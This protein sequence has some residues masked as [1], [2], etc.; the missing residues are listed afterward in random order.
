LKTKTLTTI[1]LTIYILTLTFSPA[2]AQVAPGWQ[3]G[4]GWNLSSTVVITATAGS[5]GSITPQGAVNVIIGSDQTFTISP[6]IGY[7]IS[8]LIVDGSPVTIASNYTFTNVLTT[9]TITVYFTINTFT[10]TASADENGEIDPSGE[11]IVN[12]GNNQYFSYNANDGY[13]I[14]QLLIDGV[15]TSFSSM[16]GTYAFINVQANHTIAVS[17]TISPEPTPTPTPTP[18]PSTT[19]SPN[20]YNYPTETLDLY[21]RSDTYNFSD[22]SAYGLDTDYTN[23]YVSISATTT[24]EN[25]TITYGFRVFLVT[26]TTTFQ[27]LTDGTPQAQFTLS[28]NFTGQLSSSWNCPHTI[29]TLG[30]QAIK[31]NV[32]AQIDNGTWT[33]QAT[34]ITNTLITKEL[35]P[36]TW[37]F[38]LN[39]DMQQLVGNT[40][41]I[42]TFGDSDHRSTVTGVTIVTPKYP[43]IQLWQWMNCD[44]IGLI[45]GS[46]LYIIGP[47]IYLLVYA[48]IFGSLYLRHRTASPVVFIAIIFGGGF[49]LGAWVLLPLWAALPL[50]IF[51]ILAIMAIIFKVIR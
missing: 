42:L 23:D 9:H 16:S 49:G 38:S 35:M 28:S 39:L 46:Y 48:L 1:L 3:I 45:I 41:S 12:Y 20:P 50:S 31:I 17:T 2:L 30:T 25:A 15:S 19:S 8:S 18:T 11:I 13:I 22:I 14:E 21:M 34:Y 37:G 27:E 47:V 44:F 24:T 4:P 29:V 10:I 5:G 40:T 43:D 36:A 51:V 7:S 32:Y 6:N 33:I 26:S